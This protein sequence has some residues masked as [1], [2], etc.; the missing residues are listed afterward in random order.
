MNGI[1]FSY[2]TN[3]NTNRRINADQ[4]KSD[5][6]NDP[7]FSSFEV[8]EDN[9]VTKEVEERLVLISQKLPKVYDLF[10]L[11]KN[12][13]NTNGNLGSLPASKSKWQKISRL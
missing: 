2:K 10:C 9:D 7:T 3:I 11:L 6:Q 8:I 5:C 13:F 4:K 12:D 1:Q